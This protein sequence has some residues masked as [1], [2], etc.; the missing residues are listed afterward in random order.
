M[1]KRI[2]STRSKNDLNNIHD[3]ISLDNP[4]RAK[5]YIDEIETVIDNLTLFPN[6]GRT[7]N[8]KTSDKR[9]IH[10][11]YKIIYEVKESKKTIYI[12]HVKNCAQ[13]EKS[14]F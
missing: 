13:S 6:I 2:Y 12:K 4:V 7:I 8:E 14:Q 1:F 3:Y 5:T 9:L 11:N 10:G